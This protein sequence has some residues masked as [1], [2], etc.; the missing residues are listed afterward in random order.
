MSEKKKHTIVNTKG[1]DITQA[2]DA[3]KKKAEKEAADL[4]AHPEKKKVQAKPVGNAK[5]NRIGAIVLWVIAILFEIL[6]VMVMFGKISLPFMSSTVQLVVFL[7]LDLILVII[8]NTFWKKANH[9]DPASEANPTKFWLWNNLGMIVSVVAFLPFIVLCLTQ[10]DMDKKT[11]VIA[12]VAAIICLLIAGVSGIDFNPISSEQ[13]QQAE[14]ALGNT[15]VYWT[16]FGKVYHT[17]DDCGSLNQSDVLT[18]GTVKEAVAANRTR[19]CFY[20]AKRDNIQNVA[21][22]NG[23]QTLA[24]AENGDTAEPETANDTDTDAEE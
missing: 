18:Q 10:K 7:I 13:L 21:T 6:A 11:K 16:K 12:T 1:E 9:I 24:E 8:G 5:S 15:Q 14:A 22:D 23:N 2:H 17:H 20:C 19:L 4:A 3:A